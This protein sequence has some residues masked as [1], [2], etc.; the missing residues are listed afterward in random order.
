MPRDQVVIE[1]RIY[2]IRKE[3]KKI[4]INILG[5]LQKTKFSDQSMKCGVVLEG[6]SQGA[7]GS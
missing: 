4:I 7:R 1:N 3:K 2:R 6:I 5:Y